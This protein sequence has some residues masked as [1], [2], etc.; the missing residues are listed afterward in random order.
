M[1]FFRVEIS[2]FD[3][4]A[5]TL[6]IIPE[7]KADE[8]GVPFEDKMLTQTADFKQFVKETQTCMV[9]GKYTQFKTAEVCESITEQQFEQLMSEGKAE[10]MDSNSFSISMGFSPKKGGAKKDFKTLLIIGGVAIALIALLI[11]SSLSG[12]NKSDV[13]E[14][15]GSTETV[16]TTSTETESTDTPET[17][18]SSAAESEPPITTSSSESAE[19]V[20]E[21]TDTTSEPDDEANEDGYTDS[22]YSGGSS[23]SSGESGI[24]TISFN[25]NG[26]TGTLDSIS[27]KAGQYVV[28]PSAEEAAKTVSKKGYKLIGFSDNTEIA[29][30]LYNYKMS[31]EN[32]TLFAVWEPDTFYVTYNSNGGTGQ[33][34]KAAVKYGADVPLPTDIPVYKDG[35]YLNG[36]AKT[37]GAKTALKSLKMPSENLTLYA[38]W[39]E[40]KPTAKIT[41]HFD[42]NVQVVEK[43]IGSTVDMLDS[44]GVF[45]DGYSVEGW[46]L[47]NSPVRLESLYLSEDCDVYAKWQTAKYITIT[48]DRSYLNKKAE[49]Y[50]VPCDMTGAAV[51]KLPVV[52]DKNDMFNSVFGCT[53]GFSDK[54]QT[55]EFGT[56]KYFGGTEC[57]FTKDTTLYRVLNEY[58]G[59]NGTKENPFIISCYDQLIRLSEEKASGYFIQTADIKFPSE[60]KRIPIDTKKISRGYENKSYDFFVYDGQGFTVRNLSG[61]GGLFGD[62]AGVAIKNVVIDG[63][64][65]KSGDYDT[66]GVLVNR[67]I[68]YSFKSAEEN[69]SFGT[70]NSKITNCTVKNSKIY[71]EGAKNIGG[72]VGNGGVIS[73]CY[74][75]EVSI[76]GGDNVGGIVGNACTVNGCLASGIT[77]S[78]KISSAGGISGTAYGTEIFD[79]GDKSYMSGGTII[80]CGVRT[81]TSKAVNS[82]GIVGTATADTNSAYIKSCYA[83]NI[84]LNGENNGGIAGADGKYKAHRIVYCLVDSANN[85]PVVG[86]DKVRSISRRMVLS[87]P[88]DSGLTVDGVL[89]VLNAAG[90]GFDK[91]ERSENK[92]GGYPF[93]SKITF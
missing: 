51:L 44:F 27:E 73:Y 39:S 75:S 4:A 76:E 87:V 54:K 91:W 57:K 92:N 47:D 10:E 42:D 80:G 49:T 90:S 16:E 5:K 74:A 84:Y 30:P 56:I 18:E 13:S 66:V 61:E 19:Y 28:L 29:Y 58:G 59:G 38:V 88:A 64:K 70:G 83:A 21:P 20:D 22:G 48:I 86:G 62:I 60:V 8:Q 14:T 50:K 65:I 26:G 36:W 6:F 32:V 52:D 93:P 35:L 46:Y 7:Q 85:Y 45:K 15:T 43:E 40:K 17:A 41:L 12:G 11:F 71:G 1:Y 2:S 68:S 33:L 67:V 3:D 79:D 69:D 89:S 23:S 63:A 9:D 78:G 31:Y 81:F 37:E 55:G 34:S 25:L 53:Y 82:G 72:L 24:Y 77:T